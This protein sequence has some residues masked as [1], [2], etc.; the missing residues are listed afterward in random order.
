MEIKKLTL[1]RY[2]VRTVSLAFPSGALTGWVAFKTGDILL[3]TLVGGIGGLLMGVGI[4]GR[5]Y[6]QLLAPMKRAIEQVEQVAGKSGTV[7]AE[8]L[9]TV[10]DLE[11]AF[12]AILQ[13]LTRQL[14][15]G[16]QRLNDTMLDLKLCSDQLAKSTEQTAGASVQVAAS[17]DNIRT[18]VEDIN[19][20]TD[21][22][23]RVLENGCRDLN[24]VNDNMHEIVERNKS[25]VEI[26]EKLNQQAGDVGKAI[27]LI[28][29]ITRQTNL[30]SLNAAIEASKAGEAG[31]GFAVVAEEVRKLAD[32]SAKAAQ[33]ISNIV[34]SIADSSQQ[35]AT[36]IVGGNERVRSEAAQITSLR[37]QMD[38]NLEYINKF[39]HQVSEI[40]D[41]INQIAQAIEHVS[42]VSQEHSSI[43]QKVDQ[44]VRDTDELVVS[45]KDLNNRF[46]I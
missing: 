22:V 13:E 16:V 1:G 14:G 21:Q 24:V 23:A 29:D 31:R 3:C 4:S 40:P 32:Q 33:E 7:M 19:R 44:M 35:A 43:T 18:R 36:I 34:N 28:T 6:R 5:N 2:L 39:L 30:L 17:A 8:N 38:N 42:A 11:V 10:K 27:E 15:A 12:T 46:K 25:S 37:Q 45:L 41:M 26:I 9:R 20:N